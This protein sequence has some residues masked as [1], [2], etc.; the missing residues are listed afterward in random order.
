MCSLLFPRFFTT[1]GSMVLISFHLLF[2][3]KPSW[4]WVF[5]SCFR[6][7]PSLREPSASF[8]LFPPLGTDVPR[9]HRGSPPF[10]PPDDSSTPQRSFFPCP[11]PLPLNTARGPPTLFSLLMTL[12]PPFWPK[13]HSPPP[14]E[15]VRHF[16]QIC[17]GHQVGGR[18]Y[19]LTV[20]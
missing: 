10:R 19:C 14:P 8:S 17:S 20:L 11:F 13:I 12:R 2:P 3:G 4:G 5:R 6:P 18:G 15:H 7:S 9:S 16:L 1:F